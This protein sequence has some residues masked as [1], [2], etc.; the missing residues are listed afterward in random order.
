LSKEY[1]RYV[2]LSVIQFDQYWEEINETLVYQ[3]PMTYLEL[4]KCKEGRFDNFTSFTEGISLVDNYWCLKNDTIH[5][6][7]SLAS[8]F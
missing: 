6:E 2:S 3:M 8:S 7:G 1:D 5:L 4:E